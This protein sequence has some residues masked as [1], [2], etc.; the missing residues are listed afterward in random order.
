MVSAWTPIRVVNEEEWKALDALLV[1]LD[2][3][4]QVVTTASNMIVHGKV[5]VEVSSSQVSGFHF[6]LHP[7][8]L[9]LKCCTKCCQ[10]QKGRPIPAAAS[11][12]VAE[13]A[14]SPPG[15][16]NVALGPPRYRAL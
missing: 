2:D 10:L 12:T 6:D 5:F 13:Y 3:N 15:M 7:G 4:D 16:S 8:V 14:D 1:R 11:G 9:Q